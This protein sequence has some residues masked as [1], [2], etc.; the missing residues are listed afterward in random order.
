MQIISSFF[1][2]EAEHASPETREILKTGQTRILS[3][4]LVHERLYR[5]ADLSRINLSE[6]IQDLA[7]HLFQVY[8]VDS[9]QVRL[10]TD[11]EEVSLDINSAIPFGLILNELIANAL[12]HAFPDGRDDVHSEI[13][14]IE[15]QAAY[16]SPATP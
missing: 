1:N 15:I 12:K 6:Y 14:G 13:Q 5:A 2:L 7:V 3:L 16:L 8:L 4:S 9:S 11:F 10:E